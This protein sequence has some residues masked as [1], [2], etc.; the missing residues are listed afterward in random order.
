ERKATGDGLRMLGEIGGVNNYKPL[1][2][3]H[4]ASIVTNDKN[5]WENASLATLSTLPLLWVDNSGKRFTNEDVVYDFALWGNVTYTAGGY[6][7]IIIDQDFVDYISKNELDWTGSFERTFTLLQHL[8]MTHKVGPMKTLKQELE[9]TLT[10]KAVFKAN[11]LAELAKL[12]NIDEN[13]FVETINQY[14]KLINKHADEDFYKDQKFMKFPICN[15][16]FYALKAISTTLGTVGGGLVNEKFQALTEARKV[17]SGVYVVGNNAAGMFDSA[18][19]TIEGLSNGFAWNS[20]RIAA[21]TII[22][23]NK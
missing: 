14:N 16:P 12:L 2:E 23:L 3:N 18:Y 4:A 8:P 7:Y 22:N 5:P 13:N 15:G 1:L 20:G 9:T 11:S 10:S 19:P 6:Y 21:K 17:I